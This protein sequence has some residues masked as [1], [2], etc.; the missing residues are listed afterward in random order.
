MSD[1]LVGVKNHFR[2]CPSDLGTKR[3]G[4]GV[5]PWWMLRLEGLVLREPR[6]HL[7]FAGLGSGGVC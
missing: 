7:G 2:R 1:Q 5:R 4:A 6:L 3:A